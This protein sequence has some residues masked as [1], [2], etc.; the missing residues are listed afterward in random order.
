ME[1]QPKCTKNRGFG[2]HA[3]R[4]SDSFKLGGVP[5]DIVRIV[6]SVA[7]LVCMMDGRKVLWPVSKCIGVRMYI[8]CYLRLD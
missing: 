1:Q 7:M 4:S 2:E 6:V 8:A 3:L 5:A